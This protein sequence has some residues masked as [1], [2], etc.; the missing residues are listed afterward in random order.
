LHD[1]LSLWLFSQ[2]TMGSGYGCG[3]AS[4]RELENNRF[5]EFSCLRLA[6]EESRANAKRKQ[7]LMMVGKHR[8]ALQQVVKAERFGQERTWTQAIF[9]E[10]FQGA[11]RGR[12]DK[13]GSADTG[14]PPGL[15]KARFPAR[16]NIHDNDRK[17]LGTQQV[18][19]PLRIVQGLDGEAL[20]RQS[21]LQAAGQGAVG[22]HE[23]NLHE[24]SSEVPGM[25]ELR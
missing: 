21:R 20:F 15:Q 17:W 22:F 13:H 8:Q 14:L 7:V 9:M 18:Q 5:P 25:N 1:D 24:G 16:R 4:S 2:W 12:Q 10:F 6:F 11:S 23:K 3:A 19:G